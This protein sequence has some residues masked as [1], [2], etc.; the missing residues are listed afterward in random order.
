MPVGPTMTG[1]RVLLTGSPR[2]HGEASVFVGY[3]VVSSEV[4]RQLLPLD[5]QA[6]RSPVWAGDGFLGG[7]EVGEQPSLLGRIQ[8]V[9]KANRGMARKRGGRFVHRLVGA[10]LAPRRAR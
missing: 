7:L 6:R 5:D 4:A 10:C 2:T 9:A 3:S 8:Y 1:T